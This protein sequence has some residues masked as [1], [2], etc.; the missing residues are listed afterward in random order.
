ME[1]R[2]DNLTGKEIY[3]LLS[4]HLTDMHANSPPCSVH[5][6]DL[7]KLKKPEIT[8]WTIWENGHLAGCGA[9]KELDTETAE[10]KSMRTSTSF[11]RQGVASKLLNHILIEAKNRKYKAL[12][13]E[14][15]SSPYFQAA[16]KLYERFGFNF[17]GPFSDYVSDS[18]SLFMKKE[19]IVNEN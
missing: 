18:F 9:I 8:F 15:G 19:L 5:A 6:L 10:I 16:L 14:T 11:R 2:I 3:D 17:C 13:L 4:E 1:I 7:E 12:Y